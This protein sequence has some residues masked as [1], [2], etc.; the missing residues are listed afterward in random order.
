MEQPSAALAARPPPRGKHEARRASR[1]FSDA[2][3]SDISNVMG[4]SGPSR[5]RHSTPEGLIVP[6]LLLQELWRSSGC[7]S[8]HAVDAEGRR[9]QRLLIRRGPGRTGQFAIQLAI[10][11]VA[12]AVCV[13]VCK[14]RPQKALF[15]YMY[16]NCKSE[17]NC[18]QTLLNSVLCLK[19]APF[20]FGR[21]AAT[22]LTELIVGF[23]MHCLS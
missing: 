13:H 18:L 22:D 5:P 1:T 8:N 15:A 10:R 21:V 3:S 2:P 12:R 23:V 11:F 4:N 17:L 14:L 20:A 16:A 6:D 19:T 7:H 9:G